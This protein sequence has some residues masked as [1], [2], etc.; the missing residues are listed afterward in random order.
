MRTAQHYVQKAAVAL[1][2]SSRPV[3]AFLAE[4]VVGCGG[5]VPLPLGYL[6]DVYALIRKQGGVCISD[7]VQVG[8]GRLGEWF[9]GFERHDVVPDLVIL[10]KPMG[11]GHPLGAVITTDAINASFENG[12]E[13][14]SSFGGNPVS[15]AIGMAVLDV[16]EEEKLQEQAL[17]T[18]AHLKKLLTGIKK[19]YDWI[20]D[21]RGS[22]L[23]LG[24]E[25]VKDPVTKEPY[26]ALSQYVK[27]EL[28]DGG[29]LIGTDGPYD[30]VLKI[31]PPMCF[32]KDNA[33]ELADAMRHI[34]EN[35]IPS[36]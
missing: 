35:F 16:L 10:G 32:D 14:F 36:Q 12:M 22:G 4:P 1:H 3:G 33:R 25:M 18:G 13:F 24:V 7:E 20:G 21:V 6:K 26:T 30:Q 28:R 19:E 29:F 2:N 15:C 34:L 17:E 11:N 9:W 31:K 23:F 8:F 5:Q 27:N